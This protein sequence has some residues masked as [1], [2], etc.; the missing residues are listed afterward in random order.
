[1]SD[2]SFLTKLMSGADNTSPAIGRYL[3]AFL[4]LNFLTV[5]PAVI[6]GSLIFQKANWGVW[7]ALLTALSL[8]T[9]SVV[10]SI[11]VLIRVTNS[12]EPKAPP[13]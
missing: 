10:G 6:I 3:G 5:I 2:P 1:M 12:T 8:Y 13:Q 11:T 9:P 4:F 7:S